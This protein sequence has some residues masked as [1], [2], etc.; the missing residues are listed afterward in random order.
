ML[1]F[2]PF[3]DR[4]FDAG[5][6]LPGPLVPYYVG[7]NCAPPDAGE[8]DHCVAGGTLLKTAMSPSRTPNS[9]A[10]PAFSSKT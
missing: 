1:Q 5:G 2:I 4:W 8:L 6:S 10:T 3:E 7:V 9:E